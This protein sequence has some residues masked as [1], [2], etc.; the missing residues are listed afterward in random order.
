[1]EL[2]LSKQEIENLKYTLRG[3]AFSM[4]GIVCECINCKDLTDL[5]NY[6]EYLEKKLKEC[7]AIDLKYY[8]TVVNTQNNPEILQGEL[9]DL[10]EEVKALRAQP[11]DSADYKDGCICHKPGW[12]KAPCPIHTTIGG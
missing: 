11:E 7:G 6:V 2:K 8:Q 3:C 4:Y 12:G 1:M 9:Q 10:I 5:L